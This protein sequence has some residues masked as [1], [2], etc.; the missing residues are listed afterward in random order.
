VAQDQFQS[1]IMLTAINFGLVASDPDPGAQ[2]TYEIVSPPQHGTLDTSHLPQVTYL[3]TAAGLDSFSFRA[4]DGT[5]YSN[6]A[7]VS[8]TVS[9]GDGP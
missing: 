7:T 9:P 4:F 1:A 2:L 6:T 8:I 3:G 5:D